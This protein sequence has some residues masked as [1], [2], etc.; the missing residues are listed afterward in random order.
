MVGPLTL[1]RVADRACATPALQQLGCCQLS[2]T[3]QKSVSQHE[4]KL[5]RNGHT[6]RVS[7][8]SEQQ[9]KSVCAGS[10][11]AASCSIVLS[12]FLLYYDQLLLFESISAPF[13][14]HAQKNVL[15]HHSESK[16]SSLNET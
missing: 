15:H 5:S 8:R 9:I 10:R 11:H 12:F 13:M 14:M 1:C 4:D 6:Q 3:L 16:L 7:G 2:P